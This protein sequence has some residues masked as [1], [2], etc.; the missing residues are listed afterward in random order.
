MAPAAVKTLA[1]SFE[2]LNGAT[3]LSTIAFSVV[4]I[5]LIFL[6]LV[7]Y[8]MRLVSRFAGAEKPA[9]APAAR[10]AAPAA[11]GVASSAAAADEE[12][13]AVIAAAIFAQTGTM[14]RI[15]SIVPAGTHLIGTDNVSWINC[16]R[17]EGLQGALSDRWN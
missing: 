7:I 13:V 3:A 16:G 4:F 17:L 11:A 15:K 6:T 2:G 10:A 8:A 9:A 5:V 1:S 14:M 12:L